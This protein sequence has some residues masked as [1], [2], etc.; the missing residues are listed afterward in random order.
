MRLRLNELLKMN[1]SDRLEKE[2]EELKAQDEEDK[3]IKEMKG[4]IYELKHKN[5][6]SLKFYNW[7]MGATK[8]VFVGFYNWLDRMSDP[9]HIKKQKEKEQRRK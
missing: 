9:P 3:R 2:L 8:G 4:K 7:F 1:E 6:F 5:D